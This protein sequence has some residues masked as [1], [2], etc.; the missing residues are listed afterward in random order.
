VLAQDIGTEPPADAQPARR[1]KPDQTA[2]ASSRATT[3]GNTA[4]K[5]TNGQKPATTRT[6]GAKSSG[7]TRRSGSK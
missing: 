3:N 4:R 6:T 5:A 7:S 2:T 1:R